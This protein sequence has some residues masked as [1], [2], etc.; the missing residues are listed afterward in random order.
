MFGIMSN[1]LLYTYINGNY[2]VRLWKDG[3]KERIAALGRTLRP[4]FPESIDLKITDRCDIGCKYCHENSSVYGKHAKLETIVNNL[5][6]LPQGVEIAIGGGNPLAYPNLEDLILYLSLVGLVPNITINAYHLT[7]ENRTRL[8][9]LIENTGIKGIGISWNGLDWFDSPNTVYH[10][11]AGVHTFAQI[12]QTINE[13][14]KVLILGYKRKGRGKIYYDSKVQHRLNELND[15]LWQLLGK[16][17]ISFDNLAIEQLDV[18]QHFTN[19]HWKSIYM[20][21]DGVFTMYYDAVKNEYAASSTSDKRIAASQTVI[22]YFKEKC[23]AR[24][25]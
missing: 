24:H 7:P 13:H 23:N 22:Q 17:F 12:K 9:D 3:T 20:G 21:D 2:K 1:D 18:E 25:S 16:G 14:R 8:T 19:A 15:N 6:G 5:G 11:I 10:M 4:D